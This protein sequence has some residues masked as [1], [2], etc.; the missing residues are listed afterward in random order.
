MIKIIQTLLW[1]A[2]IAILYTVYYTVG[3]LLDWI[4]SLIIYLDQK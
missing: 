3:T 4:I 1:W 2:A